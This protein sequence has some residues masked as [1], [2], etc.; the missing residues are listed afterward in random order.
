M[1]PPKSF[2][3][4][5]LPLCIDAST[6]I[7]L[8]AT[9]VAER[10]LSALSMPVLMSDAAFAE[11]KACR[12][13]GRDDAALSAVLV[14][15]GL[16][17][18][19]VLPEAAEATFLQLTVGAAAE[20]LDDGE[21]A[22]IAHALATG[23]IAVV[24]ERKATLLCR[25]LHPALRVACTIDLLA[26]PDVATQLGAGP[27]GD[28]THLALREARMRVPDHHMAWVEATIGAARMCECESVPLEVREALKRRMR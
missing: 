28:A 27:L 16:L 6:A 11:L 24:D 20:T 13:T 18:R 10:V 7:N 17:K 2:L 12:R 21:A 3:D 4:P 22:T 26:H 9:G 14:A 5:P 23:A 25:R 15:N 1:T 19:A 8:N